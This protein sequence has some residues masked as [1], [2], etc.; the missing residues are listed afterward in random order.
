[1][2]TLIRQS[3]TLPNLLTPPWPKGIMGPTGAAPHQLAWT[4]QSQGQADC[5]SAS[6]TEGGCSGVSPQ[7]EGCGQHLGSIWGTQKGQRKAGH[8]ERGWWVCNAQ[9]WWGTTWN[10]RHHQ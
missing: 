5:G 9:G 6:G 10:H 7:Q 2:K 4:G 1:M 8:Q 3:L